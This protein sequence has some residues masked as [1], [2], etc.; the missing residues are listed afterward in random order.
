MPNRGIK[1]QKGAHG[2]VEWQ[3]E[4]ANLGLALLRFSQCSKTLAEQDIYL[5]Q[6]KFVNKDDEGEDWL[7]VITATGVEGNIVTF[8]GATSFSEAVRGLGI[9]IEK[10]LLRWKKDEY[11]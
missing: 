11:S 3:K 5:K 6:V 7:V 2:S 4:L 9:K 8:H 1:D 10:N